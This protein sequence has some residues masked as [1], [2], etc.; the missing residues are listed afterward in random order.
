MYN[1][2][3]SLQHYFLLL[4]YHCYYGK[5]SKY[6]HCEY[7]NLLLLFYSSCQWNK[8][9]YLYIYFFC[10]M[11]LLAF[12]VF[13][14]IFSLFTLLKNIISLI[15]KGNSMIRNWNL[16]SVK[17]YEILSA[18][19]IYIFITF[20]LYFPLSPVYANGI[21]ISHPCHVKILCFD[22]FNKFQI[23]H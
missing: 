14:R 19:M 6:I 16:N 20:L 23:N 4:Y 12:N 3:Y 2:L 9:I 13:I 22:Y 1:K 11:V 7:F 15:Q 18:F 8:Y 10:S 21:M 5:I 17:K